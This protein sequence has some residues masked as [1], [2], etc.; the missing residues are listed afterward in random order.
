MADVNL[1]DVIRRPIF[2][3]K[4][5]WLARNRNQY[6][7]EVAPYATKPMV[8]QAIEDIFGVRVLKV[9]LIN[10][11]AKRKV[12]WQNR[13]TFVRRPGYKKAIVTLQE[14]DSIDLFEGVK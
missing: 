3:E 9:R 4:S 12:R 13:R 14:G 10:M 8:K 1:Y 5:Y 11:P 7:F 6:T 2:T